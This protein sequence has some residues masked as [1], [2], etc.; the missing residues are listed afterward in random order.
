M[1]YTQNVEDIGVTCSIDSSLSIIE[2]YIYYSDFW[3]PGKDYTN[4]LVTDQMYIGGNFPCEGE[5]KIYP[6]K[7]HTDVIPISIAAKCHDAF[8]GESPQ[9]I[10]VESFGTRDYKGDNGHDWYVKLSLNKPNSAYGAPLLILTYIIT[11]VEGK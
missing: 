9:G 5:I 6:I 7:Y 2:H 11:N 3:V 4:R 10:L 1:N 8:R